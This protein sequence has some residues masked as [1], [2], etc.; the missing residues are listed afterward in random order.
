MDFQSWHLAGNQLST[1]IQITNLQ[2]QYLRN[3]RLIMLKDNVPV[4]EWRTLACGPRGSSL[5]RFVEERQPPLVVAGINHYRAVLTSELDK[6]PPAENTILD[7]QAKD[8]YWVECAEKYLDSGLR[9]K[10]NGLAAQVYHQNKDFRIEETGASISPSG[11]LVSVKGKKINGL[12]PAGEFKVDFLLSPRVSLGQVKCDVTKTIV[13]LGTGLSEFF[14]TLLAPIL[15]QSITAR[16]EKFAEKELSTRL[17][18]PPDSLG[19][20]PHPYGEPAGVVLAAGAL[21]IYY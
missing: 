1:S 5:V 21:A 3:V 4:K 13:H 9:D 12:F 2:N 20:S 16:I 17:A 15:Y 19:K 8:L 11:I 14:S 7:A 6:T 18:K 10:S